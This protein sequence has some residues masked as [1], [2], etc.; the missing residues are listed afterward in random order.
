ML[1]SRPSARAAG[2]RLFA[3]LIGLPHEN[4]RWERRTLD[5]RSAAFDDTVSG[6][7][8]DY[9]LDVGWLN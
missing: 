2:Q 5:S 1:T 8:G 3:T 4:G 9:V 7:S 6:V